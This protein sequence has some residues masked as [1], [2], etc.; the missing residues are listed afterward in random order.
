MGGAGLAGPAHA[1]AGLEGGAGAA[2][3]RAGRARPPRERQAHADAI[4]EITLAIDHI[5]WAAKHAQKVLGERRVPA[6][7]M[8]ANQAASVEYQ[9]F[10]VIGVI[11][12]WNYPVFTPMGSSRTPW[13]LATPSCSSRV[14]SPPASDG[15]SST[16]GRWPCRSVRTSSQVVTR[17]SPTGADFAGPESTRSRHRFV[18]DG[19]KVM[20]GAPEP[21]PGPH[22]VR[23][24]GRD[25]R[26]R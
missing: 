20:A 6:G 10:G 11:G 4:L 19:K 15:G 8:A 23:R 5:E 25:D 9:P 16:R 17:L 18:R 2:D 26:R 1:P 3:A 24:Q 22:G 7:L 12:P 14:S 13:P 21:G